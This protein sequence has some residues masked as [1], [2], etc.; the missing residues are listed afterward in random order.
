LD[1]PRLGYAIHAICKA[2]ARRGDAKEIIENTNSSL[3]AAFTATMAQT[4]L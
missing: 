1:I 4:L 3:L 2:L